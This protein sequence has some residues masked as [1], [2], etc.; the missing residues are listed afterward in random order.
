MPEKAAEQDCRLIRVTPDGSLV[1][2]LRGAEVHAVIEGLPAADEVPVEY[3]DALA[4]LAGRRLK[5][6]ETGRTGAG[7]PCV[8]LRYLA[9]RDKSG[10]VWRDVADVLSGM[11]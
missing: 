3:L 2:E 7:R 8:R 4:R 6:L 5:V 10:E 9:W 11:S 1:L